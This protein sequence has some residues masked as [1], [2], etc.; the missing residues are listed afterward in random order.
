M[1]RS[2]LP[3]HLVEKF[4]RYMFEQIAHLEDQDGWEVDAVRSSAIG[5]F[6]DIL[7]DMDKL[8]FIVDKDGAVDWQG[9][10]LNLCSILD[11]IED[12]ALAAD[13]GEI[14]VLAA[15]RFTFAR[16]AGLTVEFLPVSEGEK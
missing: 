13:N 4:S 16:R 7:L 9:F 5:A 11:K 3:D 15:Y 1:N 2:K 14:S 8:G 10:A 12:Q 6:V